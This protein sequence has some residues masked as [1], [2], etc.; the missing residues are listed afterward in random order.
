MD[1]LC[2]ET[3]LDVTCTKCNKHGYVIKDFRTKLG[4]TLSNGMQQVPQAM[5]QIPRVTGSVFAISGD[6]A[7]QLDS[8]VKGM[9]SMSKAQLSILF[10]SRTTHSFMSA[11]CNIELVDSTPTWGAII[12]S[13]MCPIVVVG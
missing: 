6:E 7:S 9:C 11:G 4:A 8:L 10:G 13:P 1:R 2:S 3:I 12:T 5:N